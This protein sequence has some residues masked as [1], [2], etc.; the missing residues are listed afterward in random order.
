MKTFK[1]EEVPTDIGKQMISILKADGWVPEDEY[2]N[3]DKGID[4]DWITMRLGDDTIEFYWDNWTEWEIKGQRDIV[5]STNR[6]A[7]IDLG[8]KS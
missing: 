7:E 8:R 4:R 1:L 2:K 6:R 5:L 3:F